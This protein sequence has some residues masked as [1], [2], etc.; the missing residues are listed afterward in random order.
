VRVKST[1]AAGRG[2]MRRSEK[3]KVPEEAQPEVQRLRD[4]R[5]SEYILTHK[6]HTHP[7]TASGWSIHC[8]VGVTELSTIK[9]HSLQQLPTT[10]LVSATV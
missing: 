1:S 8:G 7:H 4:P 10:R 5:M 6:H 9:Q 3:A 2:G